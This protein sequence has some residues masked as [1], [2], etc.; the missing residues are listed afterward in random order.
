MEE[1]KAERWEME[2]MGLWLHIGRAKARK[3]ACYYMSRQ[4]WN[5]TLPS[6][7]KRPGQVSVVYAF[8]KGMEYGK[9]I[10]EK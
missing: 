2:G 4:H 8:E 10:E 3:I 9:K 1:S 7:E 6:G 5:K